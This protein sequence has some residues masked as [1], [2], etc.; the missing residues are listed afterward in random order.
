MSN[1][2]RMFWN[3]RAMPRE[4]TSWGFLPLMD[5]PLNRISPRVGL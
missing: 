1:Q 4:V 3:V 5:A 2:S